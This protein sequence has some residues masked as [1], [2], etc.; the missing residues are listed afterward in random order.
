MLRGQENSTF[1]AKRPLEGKVVASEKVYEAL[2]TKCSRKCVV[3]L[4]EIGKTHTPTKKNRRITQRLK[5]FL[6]H[7]R[8]K[9]KARASEIQRTASSSAKHRLKVISKPPKQRSMEPASQNPSKFARLNSHY[10]SGTWHEAQV[11]QIYNLPREGYSSKTKRG[12]R[13]TMGDQNLTPSFET[14]D[15]VD[16]T[17]AGWCNPTQLL[18]S[19]TLMFSA[20]SV[21]PWFPFKTCLRQH[22]WAKDPILRAQRITSK[23]QPISKRLWA[24]I[25]NPTESSRWN[26]SHFIHFAH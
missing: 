18:I 10:G 4:R 11:C 12:D 16:P 5:L 21:A 13:E 24:T 25:L 15:V 19:E 14:L 3:N 23:A 1:E 7:C 8:G 9:E 22:H 20:N 17:H 6:L 2:A 26:K